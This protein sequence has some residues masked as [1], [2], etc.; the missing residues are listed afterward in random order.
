MP[1]PLEAISPVSHALELLVGEYRKRLAAGRYQEASDVLHEAKETLAETRKE[2]EARVA[3]V[4]E[5]RRSFHPG[6]KSMDDLDE[7]LILAGRQLKKHKYELD[8]APWLQRWLVRSA[9]A[10]SL[11]NDLKL[12]R[13]LE[14]DARAT[15][16]CPER[17]PA[18]SPPVHEVKNRE[19]HPRKSRRKQ[20]REA[21][22]KRLTKYQRVAQACAHLDVDMYTDD[23]VLVD[24]HPAPLDNETCI[25]LSELIGADFEQTVVNALEVL[26]PSS[27]WSPSSSS[28]TL[29]SPEDPDGKLLAKLQGR[30]SLDSFYNN[31]RV[32]LAFAAHQ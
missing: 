7:R 9:L 14:K 25:V 16:T 1:V 19:T 20:L 28:S 31:A 8:N 2:G 32:S 11:E 12:I 3:E 17:G 26:T 22:I 29:A 27:L 4:E 23:M 24:G 21:L 10:L 18:S 30:P 6:L 13:D 5:A 15:T